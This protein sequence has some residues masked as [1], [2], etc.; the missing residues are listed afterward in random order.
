MRYLQIPFVLRNQKV[1]PACSAGART[2]LRCCRRRP[3]HPRYFVPVH[4]IASFTRDILPRLPPSPATAQ[5]HKPPTAPAGGKGGGGSAPGAS[6]AASNAVSARVGARAGQRRSEELHG[7]ARR[8]RGARTH[9]MGG[10]C[11]GSILVCL[12][13]RLSP[14]VAA[15]SPAS[16]LP[17]SQ[18]NKEGA[19]P[20]AAAPTGT[21]AVSAVVAAGVLALGAVVVGAAAGAAGGALAVGGAAAAAAA[22]AA[23]PLFGEI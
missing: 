11:I 18:R 6:M 17:F 3:A 23:V 13:R 16:P 4:W 22:A 15:A 19:A 10:S 2:R 12:L 8:D 5:P 7:Q 20:V 21:A 1:D 14:A 9:S